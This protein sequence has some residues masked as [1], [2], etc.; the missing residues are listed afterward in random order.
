MF[1]NG[2]ANH[3]SFHQWCVG[4]GMEEEME[5]DEKSRT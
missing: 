2:I 3:Q 1:V 4:R 5:W